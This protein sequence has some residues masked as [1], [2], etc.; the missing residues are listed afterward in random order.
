MPR[1]YIDTVKGCEET[2][3]EDGETYRDI[4]E[5][6]QATILALPGLCDGDLP[7]GITQH[8]RA[9]LRDEFGKVLYTADLN[10]CGK[11]EI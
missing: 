9:I 4:V 11:W 5:A 7:D 2:R 8:Y 3:D 10:F 6:R 1:F